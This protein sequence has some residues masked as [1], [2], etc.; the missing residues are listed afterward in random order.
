MDLEPVIRQHID[1]TVHLSL[2]TS[3]DNKPWV[4]EVHFAYDDHL[5]LYFRSMPSR[6]HSQEIGENPHVAGNIVRQHTLGEAPIGIYFE[7]TA[8]RLD[9]GPEQDTA[10]RCIQTRLQASEDI[11]TE[12]QQPE[13]H[14]F[15]KIIVTDYYVFGRFD[16]TGAQKYHLPWNQQ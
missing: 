16:D 4:C 8:R 2:A 6:R 5:N 9:P 10:F 14:Q 7:G 3:K 13:G 1:A 15:Y 12:A 11:L